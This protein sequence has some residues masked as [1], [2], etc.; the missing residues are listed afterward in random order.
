M[1]P[2]ILLSN[3][4]KDAR[5]NELSKLIDDPAVVLQLKDAA[6]SLPSMLA[7][8]LLAK[9]PHLAILP[10]N[11]TASFF[12]HDV[13]QLTGEKTV[14]FL[15]SSFKRSPEYGQQDT[16]SVILR[17]EALNRIAQKDK[18]Y[19]V[20]S[21]P[22]AVMEKAPS[23]KELESSTLRI[24]KGERLDPHFV[25]EVLSEYNFTKVDFV[26]EPGQYSIRGSLI[27]IYS[28]AH[29]DPYRIDFFGEEVEHPPYVRSG[30]ATIEAAIVGNRHYPQPD[31]K[32]KQATVHF[33]V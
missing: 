18:H 2:N 30:I 7:A 8:V 10:D 33:I 20:V 4:A 28:F 31:Q 25:V 11:E 19:I 26:Y 12:F 6:G 23:A 22:E 21:Y 16:A 9:G 14:F 13:M 5:V 24:S 32:A 15:P 3:Y 17:T 1:E 27:D 29:E